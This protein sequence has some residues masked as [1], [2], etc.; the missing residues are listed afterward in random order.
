MFPNKRMEGLG[1]FT[2]IIQVR[3]EGAQIRSLNDGLSINRQ[4]YP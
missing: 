2:V 4:G 3:Q 1:L